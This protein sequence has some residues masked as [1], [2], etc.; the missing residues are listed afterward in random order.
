MDKIKKMDKP[1][2]DSK[3]F[4]LKFT[5]KIN[6]GRDVLSVNDVAVSF[7]GQQVFKNVNLKIYKGEKVGIIGPN[8]IG[9]SL[10]H[11]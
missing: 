7:D 2:V 6:S 11:I 8:G 5:P 10:I 4:K 1:S 3:K 9:L